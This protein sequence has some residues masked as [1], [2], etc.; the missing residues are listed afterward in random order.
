V[1]DDYEIVSARAFAEPYLDELRALVRVCG[2]HFESH[3]DPR[4]TLIALGEARYDATGKR[5]HELQDAI[6]AHVLAHHAA[7]IAGIED[8]VRAP[9]KCTLEWRAGRIYGA[10][11]DLRRVTHGEV[12]V[13]AL[14]AAPAAR[15]LRRLVVRVRQDRHIAGAADALR[16]HEPAAP[17]EELFVLREVRPRRFAGWEASSA[18]WLGAHFP[19]LYVYGERD[20]LYSLMPAG[21]P[22]EPGRLVRELA[23]CTA[24]LD[25]FERRLIG[26]SLTSPEASVREAALDWLARHPDDAVVFVDLLG[27][28]LQPGVLAP[29]LPVLACL[30]ALGR[31]AHRVLPVLTRMPGRTAH[32]DRATRSDAGALLAALR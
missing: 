24:P 1:I 8:M 23:A 31:R 32:Y 17:I 9:R 15:W 25:A 30:R 7:E 18:P 12:T 29:Q 5:A 11:L 27:L 22:Y 16:W 20:A 28:L 19:T 14:L 6:D 10:H 26:R 3:G 4:G 13:R 21:Q 2:D